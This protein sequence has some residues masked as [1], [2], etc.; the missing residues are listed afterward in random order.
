MREILFKGKHK[1]EQGWI[2]G[3][4]NQHIGDMIFDCC[5]EAIGPGGYYIN[6]WCEKV[7]TGKYGQIY[8]VFTKSIGQFTGLSDNKGSQI[9]EGDIV[10]DEQSGYEYLVKYFEEYACFALADF[11]GKIEWDHPEDFL[12]DIYITGNMYDKQKQE[13]TA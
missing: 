6:E 5:G 3:F 7:D 2:F 4:L 13:E 10:C 12:E 8:A 11:R 9:F 1:G